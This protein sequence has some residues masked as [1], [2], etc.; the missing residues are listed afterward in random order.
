MTETKPLPIDR[1]RRMAK[2][3]ARSGSMS[4]QQAL[5]AIARSEGHDHWSQ[6]LSKSGDA[7][8]GASF[9]GDDAKPVVPVPVDA[10][11]AA[12]ALHPD[13]GPFRKKQT[14][15]VRCPGHPDGSPSLR[16][17]DGPD[18]LAVRCMAGCDAG[19]LLSLVDEAFERARSRA[20]AFVSANMGSPVVSGAS[21]GSGGRGGRYRLDDGS[22]HVLDVLVMRMLP[23]DMPRWLGVP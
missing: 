9:D 10:V 2:T 14:I 13:R 20:K 6:M 1:A 12:Q 7:R 3:I 21:I 17:S 23:E 5:D 18:G 19:R 8:S 4:H 22:D 15:V 16:L 11:S